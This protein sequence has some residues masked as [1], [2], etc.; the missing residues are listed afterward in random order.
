LE[1]VNRS[2]IEI[3]A[4]VQFILTN[5]IKEN[6]HKGEQNVYSNIKLD[7]VFM[8]YFGPFHLRDTMQSFRLPDDFNLPEAVTEKLKQKRALLVVDHDSLINTRALM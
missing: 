2:L 5:E 8:R 1:Y 4:G 6:K 3:L 7:Q